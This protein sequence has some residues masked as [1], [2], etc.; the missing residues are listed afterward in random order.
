MRHIPIK[1]LELYGLNPYNSKKSST[2]CPLQKP[3]QSKGNRCPWTT[4]IVSNRSELKPLT[5]LSSLG[6]LQIQSQ[7]SFKTLFLT[8]GVN[9]KNSLGNL[10]TV[11]DGQGRQVRSRCFSSHKVKTRLNDIIRFETV[12]YQCSLDVAKFSKF[13]LCLYLSC[14][15]LQ[16]VF[17]C[18]STHVVFELTFLVLTLFNVVLLLR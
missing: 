10:P 8:P 17:C 5:Q 9:L 16:V 6:V 3:L 11:F 2:L 15:I 1:N 18:I 13:F 14:G 4:R 12:K 7:S